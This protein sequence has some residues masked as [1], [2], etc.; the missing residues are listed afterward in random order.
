M[1]NSGFTLIELMIVVALIAILMAMALPNFTH[2]RV[3]TRKTICMNNLRQIE[4]SVDRWVF[5]NDISDGAI[6]SPGDET[7]IYSYIRGGKPACPSGGIYTIAP[8]AS[9]PQV[10]CSISGHTLIAE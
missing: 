1:K 2:I 6:V 8:I 3:T 4:S 9:Y 10:T 5:E 7:A